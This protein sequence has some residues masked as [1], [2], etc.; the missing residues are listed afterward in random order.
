MLHSARTI[1]EIPRKET[2]ARLS[3]KKVPIIIVTGK[4]KPLN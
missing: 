3:I 1:I 4:S 2:L